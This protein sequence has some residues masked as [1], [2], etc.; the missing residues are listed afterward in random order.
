MLGE[1]SVSGPDGPLRLAVATGCAR[2]RPP[3]EPA[4]RA[5]DRLGR[6]GSGP[7]RRSARSAAA[8]RS[9]RTGSAGA[10]LGGDLGLRGDGLGLG[11]GGDRLRL[12][13]DGRSG[14]AATGSGS[15]ASA[16]TGSGSTSA[17]ARRP[18]RPRWSPARAPATPPPRPRASGSGHGDGLGGRRLRRGLGLGGRRSASKAASSASMFW[19]GRKRASRSEVWRALGHAIVELVRMRRSRR[20]RGMSSIGAA[21]AVGCLVDRRGQRGRRPPSGLGSSR[22][23]PRPDLRLGPTQP[24]AARRSRPDV[25]LDRVGLERTAPLDD[26]A[27][28][29][30]GATGAA[31]DP[32]SS[33]GAAPP[34]RSPATSARRLRPVELGDLVDRVDGKVARRGVPSSPRAPLPFVPTPAPRPRR[35]QVDLAAR[36]P[37]RSDRLERR[38]VRERRRQDVLAEV[39]GAAQA[40]AL[41]VF[42]QL[43]H[44]YWRQTCRS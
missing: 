33:A 42:Q 3:A 32:G 25:V 24:A 40:A 10:A 4:G 27:T 37:P 18:G 19:P 17:A 11:L 13:G 16:A 8:I 43:A 1:S 23:A 29:S 20:R 2:R 28:T 35:R 7:G 26:S 41:G 44:V 22:R 31:L 34:Q 36:P 14:S 15:G 38:L 30:S 9:A 6:R 39:R 5:L 12:G 21:L